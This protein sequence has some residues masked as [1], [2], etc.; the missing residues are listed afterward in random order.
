MFCCYLIIVE[1]IKLFLR[2]RPT[3]FDPNYFWIIPVHDWSETSPANV[4]CPL[5]TLSYSNV[6]D[7]DI[8]LVKIDFAFLIIN[9]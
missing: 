8:L 6:I 7:I 9:E 4:V 2:K 1:K 3:D 5:G